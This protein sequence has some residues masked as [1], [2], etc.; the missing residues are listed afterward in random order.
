MGEGYF[1]MLL[2]YEILASLQ[3]R[4]KLICAV[5]GLE[6]L[7]IFVVPKLYLKFSFVTVGAVNLVQWLLIDILKPLEVHG[8]S[9]HQCCLNKTPSLCESNCK[10][11]FS[12]SRLSEI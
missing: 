6:M 2:H 10:S 12:L 9:E 5:S 1:Y 7:K 11:R 3:K 8:C 4:F